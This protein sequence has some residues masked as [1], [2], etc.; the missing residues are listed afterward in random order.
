MTNYSKPSPFYLSK[1][2]QGDLCIY[3]TPYLYLMDC[4]GLHTVYT[5]IDTSGKYWTSP[6]SDI[7]LLKVRGS[8]VFTFT[9]CLSVLLYT[10]LLCFYC[11]S[12][13]SIAALLLQLISFFYVV[14]KL[15]SQSIY[16]KSK[17][18]GCFNPWDTKKSNSLVQ[19]CL[20]HKERSCG[21]WLY[22]FFLL[23]G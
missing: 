1:L 22:S 11:P 2:W 19:Y 14:L 9:V 13:W 3:R 17:I 10:C 4:N 16:I 6:F 18:S 5:Y 20:V 8:S 7:S 12:E 15:L 23:H 21:I